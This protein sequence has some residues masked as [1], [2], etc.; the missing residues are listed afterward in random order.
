MSG[1]EEKPTYLEFEDPEDPESGSHESVGGKTSFKIGVQAEM[2]LLALVKEPK[3][4]DGDVLPAVR[5][6]M[7]A[8]YLQGKRVGQ[9]VE[10]RKLN[11]VI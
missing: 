4:L 5:Q 11:K 8:S 6:L 9:E 7:D 2:Y 3:A 10:R 1:N